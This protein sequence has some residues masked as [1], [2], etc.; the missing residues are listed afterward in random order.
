MFMININGYLITQDPEKYGMWKAQ[1]EGSYSMASA[2][3]FET[4][5]E[6]FA[7]AEAGGYGYDDK[8]PDLG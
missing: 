2:Y 4:R 3:W 7:F 1:K 5:L 8:Q 6:A